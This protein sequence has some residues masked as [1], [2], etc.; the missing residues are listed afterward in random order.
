M[1]AFFFIWGGESYGW[2]EET[3]AWKSVD[4]TEKAAGKGYT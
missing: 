2:Y 4:E 1:S 3:F